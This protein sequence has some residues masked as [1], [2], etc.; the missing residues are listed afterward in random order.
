LSSNNLIN[1]KMNYPCA[2]NSSTC[3]PNAGISKFYVESGKTYR[4]RLINGG[5][6]GE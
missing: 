2:T 1:G 5:A 4:L 6:E 3:T